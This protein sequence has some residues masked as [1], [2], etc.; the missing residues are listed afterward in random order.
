MKK[1]LKRI[2]AF[3]LQFGLHIALETFVLALIIA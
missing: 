1:W 3:F 2:G